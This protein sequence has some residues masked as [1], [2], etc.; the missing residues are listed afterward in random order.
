M[1]STFE[2]W[3]DK[4]LMFEVKQ[5]LYRFIVYAIRLSGDVRRNKGHEPC[6]K[7]TATILETRKGSHIGNVLEGLFRWNTR[8]HLQIEKEAVRGLVCKTIYNSKYCLYD[9]NFDSKLADISRGQ[10][11]RKT[12]SMIEELCTICFESRNIYELM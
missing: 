9:E 10:A 4:I 7:I 6:W 5:L 12:S 2:S 8:S 3:R 1:N 11:E